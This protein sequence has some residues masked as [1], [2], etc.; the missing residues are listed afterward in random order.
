MIA[1]V[2][3]APGIYCLLPHTSACILSP[4][5]LFLRPYSLGWMVTWS[6]LNGKGSVLFLVLRPSE[7]EESDYGC[8]SSKYG[9]NGSAFH[10]SADGKY[11]YAT[12][13]NEC[14]KSEEYGNKDGMITLVLFFLFV[15][16]AVTL[17][18]LCHS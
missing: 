15:S 4:P 10:S 5:C 7:E 16:M 11:N 14:H 8:Y 9:S 13:G 2:G 18:Y 17:F 6:Y 3:H 12:D 1:N